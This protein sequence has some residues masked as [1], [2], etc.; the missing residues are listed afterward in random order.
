MAIYET[1]NTSETPSNSNIAI[2]EIPIYGSSRLGQYRPLKEELGQVNKDLKTAL[3]QRIYEFSNHLGNVLVTLNDFKV[4]NTDGSYKSIVLSASDYYPFGMAMK[5]RTYQNEDY[6]YGFNGKENDTDFGVGKTD[7]GARIYDE[8][9]GRWL[10][11][12]PLE[13][14]YSNVSSYAFVDNSPIFF[15]DPNGEEIVPTIK[16]AK[17]L[18]NYKSIMRKIDAY[19][20]LKLNNEILSSY[21]NMPNT[22]KRKKSK[23]WFFHLQVI[24][25]DMTQKELNAT[26]GQ[27]IGFST[28]VS[29]TT[30]GNSDPHE[31]FTT[32]IALSDKGM[33][34]ATIAEEFLH[35][36]QKLYY[37]EQGL[38]QPNSISLELEAKIAKIY[39]VWD[40]NQSL[41]PIDLYKE[42]VNLGFNSYELEITFNITIQNKGGGDQITGITFNEE[43]INFFKNKGNIN[44][45]EKEKIIKLLNVAG[46][47]IEKVYKGIPGW[48][49]N[50]KIDTDLKY[51]EHLINETK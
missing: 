26:N 2:K 17:K 44:P 38:A 48:K 4:P 19:S 8:K 50:E 43:V 18:A 29:S 13:N 24:V 25:R 16:D 47:K 41:S 6:R 36:G 46:S 3:G 27:G 11:C 33:Q 22:Q 31:Y 5:E 40:N 1:I 23:A 51:F 37:K 15:I 39:A 21:T 34:F 49:P 45:A 32:E 35:A 42:M 7:F 9:I 14:Q 20:I 28:Q 30:Q 10:A 12:D